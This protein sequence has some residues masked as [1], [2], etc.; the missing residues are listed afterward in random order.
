MKK[1]LVALGIATLVA[2]PG[3]AALAAGSD[4]PIPYSVTVEGIQLP[5]GETF[6]DGGHVNVKS[7]QGDRGIHFESLN[8]QPSGQWI[9]K[10]F[11]PWSAF[12]YSDRSGL[13]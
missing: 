7:N 4:G 2:V 11:L 10:S 1:W 9:G 12:G 8:N 13:S 3:G 5:A 6:K